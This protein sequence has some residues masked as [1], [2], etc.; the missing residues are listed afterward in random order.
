MIMV[1]EAGG[2]ITDLDGGDAVLQK[3]HVAAGNEF[4]HRELLRL[5]KEASQAAAGRP[6]ERSLTSR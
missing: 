1:R 2:Y 3:G 6:A 4:I 5:L